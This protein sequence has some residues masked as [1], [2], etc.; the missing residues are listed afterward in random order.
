MWNIQMHGFDSE[1]WVYHFD[2]ET[3]KTMFVARFKYANPKRSANDFVKFLTNNFTPEEYFEQLNSQSKG[4]GIATP[5]GILKSKGYVS[6]NE[7][8]LSK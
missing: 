5:L 6:Y 8:K 1:V 7:R 4:L 3:D 2:R